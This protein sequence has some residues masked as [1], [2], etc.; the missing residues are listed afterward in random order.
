[1]SARGWLALLSACACAPCFTGCYATEPC[2]R[3]V[4]DGLDNDCDGQED[5]DFVDE[6]GRYSRPEHCGA[7]GLSCAGLYP[8]AAETECVDAADATPHCAITACARGDR[9]SEDGA[10]V[11]EPN[12]LCMACA[13]DSDCTLLR[14][15]SVCL[16]DE[17]DVGRC[18]PPCASAADC[19]ARFECA[20]QTGGERVCAPAADGCTCSAGLTGVEFGCALRT[21][22]G[23]LCAGVQRCGLA[24]L[25][26]CTAVLEERCN[27]MDDD[28]DGVVDEGFVDEQGRYASAEHCGE[29][30]RAC[31]V[32]GEHM[33]ATC[34]AEGDFAECVFGCEPGYVD[35]DSLLVTGCEC[36]LVT[37][38]G[39][40]I[41]ADA[42]CDGE[43]DETPEYVFVA[44][45][46]DDANSG[47]DAA[48]PVRTIQHGLALGQALGR[49]VLVAR[50]VY[51]GPV[52]LLAGVSLLGGYSPDFRARDPGLY[53]VLI[54][55]DRAAPAAPVLR[56][57][58]LDG[59]AMR[60]DGLTIAGADAAERGE[61]TT[62]VYLDGCGAQ[63]RLSNLTVIAGRAADGAPGAD[64]SA[65]LARFGLSSLTEL[66]G[67]DGAPGGAGNASGATCSQVAA[68]AG[69]EK[70]CPQQD[71]SGGGG[72]AAIC[73]DLSL[74]CDNATDPPCGNAGCTDFT[75]GSGVCDLDA[76]IAAAIANPSAQAGSGDAPGAA[77][78]PAYAAPTNRDTCSFCD[79][80]PSLPRH[81]GDGGDGQG[82]AP[83][84]SGTGC[85][86][87]ELVDFASG[88][89][90]A[91]AGEHGTDGS[92][93]SGGGGAT[94][95]G[96]YAVIGNTTGTCGNAA[97]GSGGGGGSGGCGAPAAS[98]GSGGGASVGVLIRL[99]A[100][101]EGPVLFRVRVVTGSGGAGGAGGIGAAGGSGGSGGIGGGSMFWCA[102]DG[103][104][105]GDG[106]K[107]GAGGG[108]GGGCGGGS[109][110]VYVAG[111]S[112]AYV[113]ALRQTV[114][115]ER[116]GIAG[117]GGAGGFS[118]AGGGGS[119]Q[120][121]VAQGIVHTPL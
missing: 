95:G 28:C 5:E 49:A 108:G 73:A 100:G 40:V 81:G 4:C 97:G 77:G 38:P 68:G 102:R 70:M 1:V 16:F 2:D 43:V 65:N 96:G 8:R 76:A 17:H 69:G 52:E 72:G 48:E 36:R 90:S 66:T 85:A 119:G 32:P 114:T 29:C 34:T 98:R 37:A 12:V 113:N 42:D 22:Q 13:A 31:A 120:D 54:E 80:N 103:G 99:P 112:D 104:R 50:G 92:D 111:A 63:L 59:A 101:A 23:G 89:V 115:V 107:G 58:D 61:G 51:A 26:A 30:G 62:A 110:G 91:G 71:V 24:G 93:G 47:E 75:D 39:A 88:R 78:V 57:R 35:V 7:C 25:G 44:P 121:G 67:V 84:A 105:G 15:G 19:P 117:R 21:E 116:A 14:P 74:A 55:A 109:Y 87:I 6:R 20:L 46:G 3:E 18:A 27:A 82:G 56:C 83:G 60:V 9:L 106:G 45:I 11:P 79:D 33:T 53:P 94:A 86:G 118:P 10:C 41:G 64:S